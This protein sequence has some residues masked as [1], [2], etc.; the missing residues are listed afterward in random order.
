[1]SLMLSMGAEMIAVYCKNKNDLS[2]KLQLNLLISI[3]Y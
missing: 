3:F 2:L 1:M